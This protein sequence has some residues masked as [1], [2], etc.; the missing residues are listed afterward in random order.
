MLSG[1]KKISVTK[2]A[3]DKNRSLGNENGNNRK[4]EIIFLG[5]LEDA[6]TWFSIFYLGNLTPLRF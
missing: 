6:A 3:S 4:N 2:R 5:Y 1:K